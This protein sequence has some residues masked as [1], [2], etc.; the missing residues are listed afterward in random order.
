M[1]VGEGE[2]FCLVF[3]K[4]EEIVGQLLEEENGFLICGR[5]L[6]CFLCSVLKS[7]LAESLCPDFCRFLCWLRDWR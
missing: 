1:I 2:R 6:N 7:F 5:L 3:W 4:F